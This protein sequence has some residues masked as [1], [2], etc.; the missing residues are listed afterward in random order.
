MIAKFSVKNYRSIGNRQEISFLSTPDQTNRDLMTQEVT[1]SV[2]VNKLAV[3]F[4]SNASGK[5]NILLAIRDCVSLLCTP[6]DSKGSDISCYIPFKLLDGQTT[7]MSMEFYINAVRYV[8]SV[9]FDRHSVILEEL[10]WYP[11]RTRALIYERKFAGQD[12]QPEVKF[13]SSLK[14][15][16]K[17]KRSIIEAVYNNQ[18][19]LST[20]G[21]LSLKDDAAQLKTLWGWLSTHFHCLDDTSELKSNINTLARI[22]R[23]AQKKKFYLQLLAKADFNITNFQVLDKQA[24]ELLNRVIFTNHSTE[25]DFEIPIELQSNGTLRFMDLLEAL[26]S[27]VTSSQVYIL[28]ELGN[29][30]HYD[31]IVYYLILFL[32]NSEDSQLFFAS[33]SILLLDEEQIMRRDAIYLTEKDPENAQTTYVRANELGLHKNASLYNAYRAGRFGSKPNL[34]SPYLNL[35]D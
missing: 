15:G 11:V 18:S 4:G 24:E 2:Y 21:K 33:Q 8:Y 27:M 29:R 26:Y 28:D 12:L 25:G 34:G 5:S 14:L 17:T 23:D 10:Y 19:V 31:L 1:P 20:M 6:S 9:E 16:A 35:A 22:H 32:Y 13:G 3:F 30:M 7:V